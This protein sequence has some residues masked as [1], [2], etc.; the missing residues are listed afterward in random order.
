M[1]STIKHELSTHQQN[2]K[3]LKAIRNKVE[4]TAWVGAT[5]TLSVAALWLNLLPRVLDFSAPWG[6]VVVLGGLVIIILLT[7]FSFFNAGEHRR[8]QNLTGRLESWEKDAQ[9]VNTALQEL[10]AAVAAAEANPEA[11]EVPQLRGKHY[12]AQKLYEGIQG[13]STRGVEGGDGYWYSSFVRELRQKEEAV[14]T[15]FRLS[16][17]SLRARIDSLQTKTIN[18]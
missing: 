6:M 1:E 4:R 11:E 2:T 7:S 14:L 5:L 18:T 8:L 13:G 3:V 9:Q 12:D 10:E 17:D 16:L 15:E